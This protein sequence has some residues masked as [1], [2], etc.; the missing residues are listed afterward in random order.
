MELDG[1][2]YYDVLCVIMICCVSQSRKIYFDIFWSIWICLNMF[3]DV[4]SHAWQ[5]D[6]TKH[7]KSRIYK[8]Y[9]N[10]WKYI[11]T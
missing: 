8:I 7:E 5:F 10:I 9:E 11:W 2:S 6:K 3:E 1:I 4:L